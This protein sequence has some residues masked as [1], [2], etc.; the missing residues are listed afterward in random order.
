M[1]AVALLL[2][3]APLPQAEEQPHRAPRGSHV[4]ARA[5]LWFPDVEGSY[6]VDGDS[7]LGTNLRW[8]NSLGID[9]L[10]ACPVAEITLLTGRGR[11]A[12]SI[13]GVGVLYAAGRWTDSQLLAQEERFEGSVFPAGTFVDGE[14]SFDQFGVDVKILSDDPAAELSEEF[15]IGLH[16]FTAETI[17]RSGGASQSEQ[18]ADL[19]LRIGWRGDWRPSPV[20]GFSASAYG[21]ISWFS[22]FLGDTASGGVEAELSF[23]AEAQGFRFEVGYRFQALG[24]DY[25]DEDF[26]LILA[27]VT[28][29]VAFRF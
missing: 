20:M 17:I 8:E 2:A 3:L 25:G 18:M 21:S 22:P 27:G 6:R 9:E 19:L 13:V 24:I 28:V 12:D 16:Y 1:T 15:A 4:S 26:D 10:R 29:G 5:S 7:L 11:A 14:F 23:F